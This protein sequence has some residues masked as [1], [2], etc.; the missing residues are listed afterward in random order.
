MNNWTSEK[1][2]SVTG[3]PD[4]EDDDLLKGGVDFEG[5]LPL[6]AKDDGRLKTLK[7]IAF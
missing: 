4:S 6:I 7:L 3:V 5:C 2:C 1:R